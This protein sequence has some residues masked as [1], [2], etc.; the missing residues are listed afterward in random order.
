MNS[1]FY[2]TITT[3]FADWTYSH[4]L[5]L[6]AAI[7]AMKPQVV[8]ECGLYRAF[9]ACWMA[10]ALQ[11][12]NTGKL[13]AIDNFSL[14]EHVERYGDPRTH[15]EGNLKALGVDG[16]V[17]IHEGETSDP[18][19]WPDKVD[20]CYIDA[21]HSHDAA[22]REFEMAVE[23][24]AY[25]IAL[26]DTENCVGPRLF[27]EQNRAKYDKL[28][29]DVM[30]IHSDNGLTIFLKRKPRRPITFSQE[31]PLPNPGVDLRPLTLE[32]QAEHFA[33]AAKITKLDYSE[34][35]KNTE[36]DLEL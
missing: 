3:R 12:N 4:P 15:A 28:G 16:W 31:L 5:F 21:W 27:V 29:W 19:M 22:K 35:L 34:C 33:E 18:A 11:E 14:K 32:Q 24:G 20:V 36:H 30:D 26:D 13:V 17:E 2:D 9:A 10:R 7:R 25:L 6:Y 1:G 8:V 23:R